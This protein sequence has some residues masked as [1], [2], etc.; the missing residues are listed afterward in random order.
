MALKTFEGKVEARAQKDTVQI[1]AFDGATT[2][3]LTVGGV[4]ISVVG[5][6]DVDTT[7]ANLATAWNLSAHP[8]FNLVTATAVTDTITLES[9]LPGL[10]FTAVSS[11]TGGA[12]TI[13]AITSVTTNGSPYDLEDA[14]NWSN[15]IFPVNGDI[16]EFPGKRHIAWGLDALNGI[17]PAGGRIFRGAGRI[18]LRED[19]VAISAD[20]QGISLLAPEYRPSFMEYPFDTLDLEIGQVT[21]GGNVPGSDRIKLDLSGSD[22]TVHIYSVGGTSIDVGMPALRFRGGSTL[23]TFVIHEG[24]AAGGGVGFGV[25]PSTNFLA[26]KVLIESTL[27]NDLIFIGNGNGSMTIQDYVQQ[28]GTVLAQWRDTL[29]TS[30]EN[31][32]TNGGVLLMRGEISQVAAHA[33]VVNGGDV[34]L[35]QRASTGSEVVALTLNGGIVRCLDTDV[36]RTW[37]AV[38]HNGG[39]LLVDSDAVTI[40][41]YNRP[42]GR[43]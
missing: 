38:T 24:G 16:C 34:T 18:G 35:D 8:Y 7:A 26:K 14:I 29:A 21:G 37:D 6:T 31:W 32:T 4:V 2:Y 22:G 13:G 41:A 19:A 30:I 5:D 42:S 11:V 43:K 33:F 20:G 10:P 1:T 23:T 15:E 17:V 36:Q 27:I 25:E 28:G 40:T 39:Q 12:G 3:N 9:D